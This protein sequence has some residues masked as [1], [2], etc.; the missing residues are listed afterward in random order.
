M[1]RVTEY[2]AIARRL[3]EQV[4]NEPIADADGIEGLFICDEDRGHYFHMTAGWQNNHWMYAPILHLRIKDGKI[5]VEHNGT[6]EGI[7]DELVQLGV[8]VE[9][10]VYGVDRLGLD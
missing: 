7:T 5:V 9:D 3:V 2:R 1:D 4:A 10:I 6:E 8:L